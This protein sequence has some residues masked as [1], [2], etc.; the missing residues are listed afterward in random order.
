MEWMEMLRREARLKKTPMERESERYVRIDIDFSDGDYSACT[1]KKI[2]AFGDYLAKAK[3]TG[4]A[5][6]AT[7]RLGHRHSSPIHMSEFKKTYAEYDTL[8]L[9]TTDT[10][11]HLVLYI[12]R[13]FSGEVDPSSGQEVKIL[14][15]N[16][17]EIDV[18]QDKRFTAHTT[19]HLK[20]QVGADFAADKISSTS[21]K[22]RW[23]II[24][25]DIIGY[26]GE[27]DV[28]SSNGLP[29][30]ADSYTT[31]E[32]V[33]LSEVYIIGD[34]SSTRPTLNVIYVEEA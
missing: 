19:A 17:T 21:L 12:G 16:G 3:Y 32:F 13:A 30:S 15:T 23:C 5:G 2:G 8:Y 34:G 1:M 4:N 29:L 7:L 28:T 18:A 20:I 31:F 25:N 14:H 10:S 24:H 6:T 26:F 9:T 33:D 27:S 11:G 22:V